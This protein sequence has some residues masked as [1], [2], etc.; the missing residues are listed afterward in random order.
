MASPPGP[1]CSGPPP[2]LLLL[3][4]LRLVAWSPAAWLLVLPQAQCSH[5]SL[6]QG[7]QTE[8]RVPCPCPCPFLC[9][10]HSMHHS[11]QASSP[12]RVSPLW[13][14]QCWPW[15]GCQQ[16]AASEA[17]HSPTHPAVES[18]AGSS[19]AFESPPIG[20]SVPP[21]RLATPPAWPRPRPSSSPLSR[22]LMRL[23]AGSVIRLLPP[24][25]LHIH[26]QNPIRFRTHTQ[27][28]QI[29]ASRRFSRW[30]FVQPGRSQHFSLRTRSQ[31]VHQPVQPGTLLHLSPSAHAQRSPPPPA[32]RDTP[33]SP[34]LPSPQ[35]HGPTSDFAFLKHHSE[36]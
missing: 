32:P 10:C 2:A 6:R 3:L 23:Q 14:W 1:A 30:M 35:P 27:S 21:R 13:A 4:A 16:A 15:A 12:T 18:A 17:S 7:R 24:C 25:Q 31:L 20:L 33:R 5:S 19:C 26:T 36:I 22:S 34:P 8:A 29:W 9:C 28:C 11:P